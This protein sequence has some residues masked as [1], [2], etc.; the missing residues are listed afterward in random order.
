RTVIVDAPNTAFALQLRKILALA[1]LTAG[2]HYQLRAVGATD[3]R[4]AAM[5]QDKTFAATLL[6][7]S[8]A[9]LA[10]RAGL[11]R[12]GAVSRWIGPY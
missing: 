11:K 4:A 7:P 1:G 8:Y 9:D 6:S 5:I 10:E 12:L 3:R 2:V